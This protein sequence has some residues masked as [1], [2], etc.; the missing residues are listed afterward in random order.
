[1]TLLQNAYQRLSDT[2]DEA[3]TVCAFVLH[4]AGPPH[5]KP[6]AFD[7]YSFHNSDI[8]V[9]GVTLPQRVVDELRRLGISLSW[10]S[11][12]ELEDAIAACA[13]DGEL[14][15]DD[16]G[17]NFRDMLHR[18]DREKEEDESNRHFYRVSLRKPGHDTIYPDLQFSEI[19][20]TARQRKRLKKHSEED[21]TGFYSFSD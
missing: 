10:Y 14:I 5:A 2:L 15:D 1:M 13:I 20:T 19:I 6:Y 17:I 4:G 11:A 7:A 8:I 9:N 18:T 16:E 12:S 3:R 21:A